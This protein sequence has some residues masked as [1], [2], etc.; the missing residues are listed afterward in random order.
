[1]DRIVRLRKYVVSAAPDNFRPQPLVRRGAANKES[2]FQ[3]KLHRSGKQVAP[4]A[5]WQSHTADDVVWP[6]GPE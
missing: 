4:V 1:M 3:V 5:V 2:C 6:A